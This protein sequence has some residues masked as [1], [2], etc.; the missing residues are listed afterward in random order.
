M[1]KKINSASVDFIADIHGISRYFNGF[2]G[3]GITDFDCVLRAGGIYAYNM[4]L[5]HTLFH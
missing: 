1:S 4:V 5:P 3:S 2:L